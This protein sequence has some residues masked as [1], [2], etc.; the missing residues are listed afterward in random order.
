MSEPNI[1]LG[2]GDTV[3]IVGFPLGLAQA[4]GLAIWK[5]GTIASDLDI[6]Y[7]GNLHSLL[8]QHLDRECRDHLF[9]LYVMVCA[10]LVARTVSCLRVSV[11]YRAG[12]RQ[13]AEAAQTANVSPCPKL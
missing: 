9:T 12:A 13:R 6:N 7:G 11:I 3:T 8:T 1:A 4:A 2:P 5:T 10:A